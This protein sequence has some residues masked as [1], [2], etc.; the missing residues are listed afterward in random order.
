MT[1]DSTP[2]AFTDQHHWSIVSFS[3]PHQRFP[4]S[5]NQDGQWIRAFSAFFRVRIIEREDRAKRF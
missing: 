1:S 3:G 2:H 4:M 5:R